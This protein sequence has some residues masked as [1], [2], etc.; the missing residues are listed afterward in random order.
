MQYSCSY[1][2]LRLSLTVQASP[3]PVWAEDNRA[4]HIHVRA[5][6]LSFDGPDGEPE[7]FEVKYDATI[8]GYIRVCCG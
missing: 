4:H 8:G 2:P 5:L 7:D 1:L 6:P 3:I